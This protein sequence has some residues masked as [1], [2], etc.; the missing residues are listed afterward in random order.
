MGKNLTESIT[1]YKLENNKMKVLILD[2]YREI[3]ISKIADIL[4]SNKFLFPAV[5]LWKIIYRNAG[6]SKLYDQ[7]KNMLDTKIVPYG[8][9]ADERYLYHNDSCYTALLET[10]MHLEDQQELIRFLNS[11][12]DKL[13]L[14]A[15]FH[16]DI[17][18][19]LKTDGYRYRYDHFFDIN[20]FIASLK[21]EEK[22]KVLRKYPSLNFKSLLQ[23]LQLL[24]FDVCLDQD[25]YL[26]ALPFSDCIRGSKFN[27]SLLDVWLH[28]E[29]EN[30]AKS[31]TNAIR[32]YSNNDS[33]AC[34]S[35]CRNIITGI[36]STKKDPQRKWMDGL[37]KVCAN[38]RN[39]NKID[40]NKIHTINYNANDANENN[41]YQY[42]RYNLIYRL[43]AFS[44]ALGA[45][46]NEGNTT[47]EGVDSE[48]A[49]PEDAFL[50]LRMTEDMLIWLYQ[51]SINSDFFEET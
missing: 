25:N 44:S 20:E 38:D 45:H 22:N 47:S 33:V 16:E 17:E 2:S 40:A 42:P 30:I 5:D 21:P 36:F 35:H 14:V 41:R 6:Q 48:I 32:S 1:S 8:Y 31:Y 28:S 23:N 18:N 43:Y 26:I 4:T 12:L 9:G 46:I 39:I 37:K 51:N 3:A 19:N 50:C 7:Y 11:I 34:I 27:T 13:S 24:G 10:L 15:V 29:Y 49:L